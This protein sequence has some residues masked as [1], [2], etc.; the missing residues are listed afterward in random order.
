L[1]VDD[2]DGDLGLLASSLVFCCACEDGVEVRLLARRRKGRGKAGGSGQCQT[3]TRR[4]RFWDRGS[5]SIPY[6]LLIMID[7]YLRSCHHVDIEM[8]WKDGRGKRGRR[9]V[10]SRLPCSSK[11]R[12][13]H[14]HS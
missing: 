12:E 14:I 10:S 7:C 4:T 8:V 9:E 5:L 13:G 1:L 11:D 6:R 3:R 2:F